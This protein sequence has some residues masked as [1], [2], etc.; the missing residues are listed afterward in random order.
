MAWVGAVLLLPLAIASTWLARGIPETSLPASDVAW[1][2]A[3]SLILWLGFIWCF[4]RAIN[5]LQNRNRP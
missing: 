2:S 3:I 4:G 5:G 1:L